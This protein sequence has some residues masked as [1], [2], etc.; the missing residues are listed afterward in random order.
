MKARVSKFTLIEKKDGTTGKDWVFITLFQRTRAISFE[1]LYYVCKWIGECE[2]S[3]YTEYYHKGKKMV[4]EFL[5][6]AINNNGTYEQLA[7]KYKLPQART[8]DANQGNLL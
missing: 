5:V 4:I 2:D 3:K 1:E 6:D 8:R 7:N